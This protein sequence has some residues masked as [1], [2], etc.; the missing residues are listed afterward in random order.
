MDDSADRLG[1]MSV[2]LVVDDS[3]LARTAVRRVLLRSGLFDEVWLAAGGAEALEVLGGGEAGRLDLVLC[4]LMMPEIDGFGLLERMVGDP[5]LSAVPPPARTIA[6]RRAEHRPHRLAPVPGHAAARRRCRG[7]A[8]VRA[9][10]VG[11][12]HQREVALFAFGG[13]PRERQP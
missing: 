1:V 11:A 13:E 8:E 6:G 4:D 3:A 9:A 7:L 5:R 10:L 2:C 12:D